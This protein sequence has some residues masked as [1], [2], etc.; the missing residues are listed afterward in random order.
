MGNEASVVCGVQV[1]LTEYVFRDCSL[2]RVV[3]FRSL[4]LR[5]D[6]GC[7]RLSLVQWM[8]TCVQ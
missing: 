1:E 3:W 8:V 6:S 7:D 4:G 5:V 2:A